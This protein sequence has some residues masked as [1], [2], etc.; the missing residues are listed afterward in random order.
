MA[1]PKDP[2][3]FLTVHKKFG[4]H[5]TNTIRMIY[6]QCYL[7]SKIVVTTVID[8]S[9]SGT[10]SKNTKFSQVNLQIIKIHLVHIDNAI[11][12]ECEK[13]YYTLVDLRGEIQQNFVDNNCYEYLTDIGDG[14]K[15]LILYEYLQYLL[16]FCTFCSNLYLFSNETQSIS[17]TTVS[18]HQFG[19]KN[20][21]GIYMIYR[22]SWEIT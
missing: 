18:I 10:S 14:H 1:K 8:I 7:I 20:R 21:F 2:I 4:W 15:N 11:Q 6:F 13:Q 17:N 16:V 3:S 12:H 19:N 5:I 9:V 22:D